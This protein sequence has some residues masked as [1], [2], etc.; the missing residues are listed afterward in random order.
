MVHLPCHLLQVALA[1]A[2][3][4]GL[5]VICDRIRVVR[6]GLEQPLPPPALTGEFNCCRWGLTH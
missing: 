3:R 5:P 4:G 6:H 2:G 1:P